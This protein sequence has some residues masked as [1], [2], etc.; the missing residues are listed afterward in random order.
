MSQQEPLTLQLHNNTALRICSLCLCAHSYV[1]PIS[2]PYQIAVSRN[3]DISTK[4]QESPEAERAGGP[5]GVQDKLFVRKRL[6]INEIRQ[7]TSNEAKTMA[8]RQCAMEWE[9]GWGWEC[10]GVARCC[11]MVTMMTDGHGIQA[12]GLQVLYRIY[13]SYCYS[14]SQ[15]EKNRKFPFHCSTAP[16]WDCHCFQKL[17][18]KF[19]L[20]CAASI[21]RFIYSGECSQKAPS[22]GEKNTSLL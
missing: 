3:V 19:T 8:A 9:G 2:W 6:H 11:E 12:K 18:L 22:S 21:V 16:N 10:W 17:T 7:T 13:D 14:T 4:Q 15:Y 5:W 20:K 1:N